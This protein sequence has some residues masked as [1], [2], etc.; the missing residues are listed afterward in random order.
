MLAS[1]HYLNKGR[2]KKAYWTLAFVLC[3]SVATIGYQSYKTDQQFEEE[4]KDMLNLFKA[5]AW[6]VSG[7]GDW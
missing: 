4:S 6:D 5:K 3:C 1:E 7:A 2:K